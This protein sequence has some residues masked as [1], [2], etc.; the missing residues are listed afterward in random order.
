MSKL[1]DKATI[2]K[3]LNYT[4]KEV[5]EMVMR[6]QIPHHS[7]IKPRPVTKDGQQVFKKGAPV[8]EFDPAPGN[9]LFPLEEIMAKFTPRPKTKKKAEPEPEKESE[10]TEPF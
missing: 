5:D 7:G 9:I 8:I 1:V 2:C 4:S 10:K 3:A 6:K